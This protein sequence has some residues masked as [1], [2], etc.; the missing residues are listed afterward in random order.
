MSGMAESFFNVWASI[1]S[2]PEMRLFC[3]WH[4][5]RAWRKN[6]KKI[7]GDDKQTRAYKILRALLEERDRYTFDKLLQVAPQIFKHD[8]DMNAFGH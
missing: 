7:K 8:P 2:I 5:D 4:V 6:L 3:A 1:M